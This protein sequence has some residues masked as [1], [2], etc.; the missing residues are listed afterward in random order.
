[1][2]ATVSVDGAMDVTDGAIHPDGVAKPPAPFS[3]VVASGD[4]VYTAGQVG[5]DASGTIVEGGVE[6]QTRRALENVRLCLAAAGCTMDDVVK[7]NAY[8]TDMND[9]PVYNEVYREFFGEPYPARTTVGAA[10]A[11][12]L[13]VEIEAIARRR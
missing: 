1:V 3:P 5:A 2:T 13:V 8:L 12:G 6:A 11:P 10:L 7:V 9:F 4:L